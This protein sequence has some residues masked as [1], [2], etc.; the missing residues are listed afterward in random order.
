MHKS[1]LCFT[2][3]FASSDEWAN[4]YGFELFQPFHGLCIHIHADGN[5]N[6]N[7]NGPGKTGANH[8]QVLL[9]DGDYKIRGPNGVPAGC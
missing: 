7:E 5:A 3:S 8:H 9:D 1:R 4:F 6:A 2:W